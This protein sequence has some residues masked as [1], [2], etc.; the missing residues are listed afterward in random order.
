MLCYMLMV[1]LCLNTVWFFNVKHCSQCCFFLIGIFVVLGLSYIMFLTQ[2]CLVFH[3]VLHIIYR[4]KYT[5]VFWA[6]I[7]YY[8]YYKDGCYYFVFLNNSPILYH[9]NSHWTNRTILV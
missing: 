7:D 2:F 1:T 4:F 3:E 5:G 9:L 6:S 8:Q